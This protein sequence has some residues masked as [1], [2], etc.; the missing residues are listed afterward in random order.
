[1]K[2]NCIAVNSSHIGHHNKEDATNTI[3]SIRI[4]SIRRRPLV[5]TNYLQNDL[6]LKRQSQAVKYKYN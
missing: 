3:A 1:M 6:D 5:I 4:A 2:N